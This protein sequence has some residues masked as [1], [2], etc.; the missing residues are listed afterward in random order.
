MNREIVTKIDRIKLQ[1]KQ[2]CDCL[3]KN[4]PVD[5][6]QHCAELGEIARRLYNDFA[7]VVRERNPESFH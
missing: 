7:K 6:M 3:N 4:D 5:A 1:T 2:I